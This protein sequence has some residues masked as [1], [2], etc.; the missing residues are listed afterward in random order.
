MRELAEDR[1]PEREALA[2]EEQGRRRRLAAPEERLL[3][4]RGEGVQHR[5]LRKMS[6]VLLLFDRE[7][8]NYLKE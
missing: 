7:T 8:E 4:R 1:G 2:A 5:D 6:V 3:R